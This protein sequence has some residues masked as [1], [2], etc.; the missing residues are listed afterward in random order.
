MLLIL[1]LACID[2]ADKVEDSTADSGPTLPAPEELYGV[3]NVDGTGWDWEPRETW[4]RLHFER[5]EL[6]LT[7]AG[8]CYRFSA[9]TYD[10]Y[11]YVSGGDLELT[12]DGEPFLGQVD[13]WPAGRQVSVRASGD[14]FPEFDL[15][16]G[17]A[18]PEW[19]DVSVDQEAS[20]YGEFLNV[21]WAPAAT[22][23]VEVRVAE[24]SDPESTSQLVCV[25]PASAGSARV[26]AD[27]KTTLW[28]A[29]FV[30]EVLLPL[31]PTQGILVRFET[32]LVGEPLE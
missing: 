7:E 6:P 13:D 16:E 8:D 30:T 11:F 20:T 23:W 25:F 18:T 26:F 31:P 5:G 17:V 2:P 24:R 19:V 27:D 22:G 10:D 4:V 15:G 1:L 14:L 12:L 9:S 32:G 3:L 21:S 28:T 29:S